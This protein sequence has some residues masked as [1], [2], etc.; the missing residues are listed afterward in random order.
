[1]SHSFDV[2]VAKNVGVNAAVLYQNIQFWCAKNKAN[3]THFHDG[4][5]W[6]YNSK[7]AFAELFPYMT[8][9]QIDYALNKLVDSGYIIK[10]NYNKSPY[11]KT[12]WYADKNLCE[13]DNTKLCNRENESEQPIPYSKP[14]SKTSN[15][16][17]SN[18]DIAAQ[19]KFGFGKP[20]KEKKSN[21]SE[22]EKAIDLVKSRYSNP[23][24]VSVLNDFILGK[25]EQCSKLQYSFS[26]V[27]IKNYLDNLDTE[28]NTDNEK[29]GAVQLSIQYNF[30]TKVMKPFSNNNSV[31]N[32]EKITGM[33]IGEKYVDEDKTSTRKEF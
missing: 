20:K 21:N 18:D 19:Q 22:Y 28:L 25:K 27:T 4:Y 3:E 24:L 10:G 26:A 7:K 11:D 12:L 6:T 15:G 5:Y 29:I 16:I 9:R 1:M 17:S 13:T 8:E 14:V 32:I 30:T 31:S 2:E 23:K 33:K